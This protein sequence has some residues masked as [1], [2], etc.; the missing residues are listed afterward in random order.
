M[1]G[2]ELDGRGQRVWKRKKGGGEAEGLQRKGLGRPEG[3]GRFGRRPAQKDPSKPE[4]LVQAR[5][6][7]PVSCSSSACR[8]SQGELCRTQR[9]FLE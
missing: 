3:K 4:G 7:D 2:G 8:D 6:Q 1:G 9:C 5:S